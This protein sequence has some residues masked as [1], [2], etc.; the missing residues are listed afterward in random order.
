MDAAALGA[1]PLAHLE[2]HLGY[3]MPAVA[4]PLAGGIPAVDAYECAPVP[5][6][7]VFQLAQELGPT[8]VRD[9][10]GE[11]PV[12]LHVA[13]GQRLH[14]DHLVLA[15]QPCGELVQE[16]PA[17]VGNVGMHPGDLDPRLGAVPGALDLLGKPALQL[18][19]LRFV[20]AK[21]VRRGDLLA[22]GEDGEV[23]QAQVDADLGFGSRQCLHC[24]VAQH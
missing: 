13:D 2:W 20:L 24:V 17:G 19:E 5:L 15:H 23:R 12:L 11:L 16:I 21:G 7:L 9:G 1:G 8:R 14:G 10:L 4:A 22:A 6:R 3:G 18:G